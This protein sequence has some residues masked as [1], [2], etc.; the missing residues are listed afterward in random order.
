MNALQYV[1][2]VSELFILPDNYLRIKALM[3]SRVASFDEISEVILLDPVLTSKV[4]RL[5]NSAIYNLSYQVDTVG[6]ALVVLGKNQV[7]N[8]MLSIGIVAACSEIN[9]K[10]I[11]VERFWEQSI[12]A[13]LI[14]KFLAKIKKI[15]QAD[16]IYV[17]GLLHNIGEL[18]VVYNAPETA[19]RC[20]N[21]TTEIPPWKKQYSELGF[22]Y[23]ECSAELLHF[24]RLPDSIVEP[25]ALQNS[26]NFTEYN[27]STL[28]THLAVRLALINQH[29]KL[30]KMDTFI[31]PQVTDILKLEQNDLLNAIDFCNTESLFVLSV[32]NPNFI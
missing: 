3:D 31:D 22:T 29:P 12:N 17:S 5:A 11:D 18:V 9:T 28:I 14:A 32:L 6:K 13:A 23:A 15:K 27:I 1:Q 8:M 7:Y 19:T 10:S 25:I 16:T 2:N 21:Y 4:L 20:Q 30:Y 26:I 24:W